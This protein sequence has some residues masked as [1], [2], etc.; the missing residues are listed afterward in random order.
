MAYRQENFF[1]IFSLILNNQK[2]NLDLGSEGE[3][4]GE[5]DS[6]SED[7]STEGLLESIHS[8]SEDGSGTESSSE[9][10]GSTEES[11]SEETKGE[12]EGDDLEAKLNSLEVDKPEEG[13]TNPL[14]EELNKLGILH[15]GLP[16]EFDDLDKAKE[17]LSKGYDYTQKTQELSEARKTFDSEIAQEREA[18]EGERETFKQEIAKNEGALTNYSVFQNMIQD[19]QQKDPELF[20]EL[21]RHYT[22]H[23]TQM[24]Q[25]SPQVTALEQKIA[26]LEGRL[27]GSAESQENEKLGEIK[28]TWEKEVSELQTSFG[29][30]FRSLG[31]KPDWKKIE[32]TWAADT[33]NSLTVKSALFA[34]Y[35]E[36]IEKAMANKS[37]LAET[38]A[39]V[40]RQGSTTDTS[41]DDSKVFGMT[42]GNSYENEAFELL[43]EL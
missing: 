21:D 28:Q 43:K 20:E 7:M 22:N 11:S 36:A 32:Q 19:I 41:E 33:T 12:S 16:V 39:K 4:S 17:L 13:E 5:A 42:S 37:K 6:S 29:P 8:G 3:T 14:L 10:A 38:R 26:D 35:G 30:K 25:S 2:G 31:I 27:N 23:Q 34:Q 18:F 15:N 1:K 9:S 40:A 24:N